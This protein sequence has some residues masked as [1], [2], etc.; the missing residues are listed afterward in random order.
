MARPKGATNKV[1]RDL[2]EFVTEFLNDNIDQ[3]QADFDALEPADR[4]RF[5]EKLLPFVIPRYT[6]ASVDVST[7]DLG[8]SNLPEWFFE[9][10]K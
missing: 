7:N 1:T 5:I 10:D 2:R 8:A 6:S 4:L 9:G 3:M